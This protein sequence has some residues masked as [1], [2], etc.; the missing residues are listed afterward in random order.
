[1]EL[2]FNSGGGLGVNCSP[3]GNKLCLISPN[4]NHS[5]IV[6]DSDGVEHSIYLACIDDY[7]DVTLLES[8]DTTQ[9]EA[10]KS[11][12]EHDLVIDIP[13]HKKLYLIASFTTTVY[14]GKINIYTEDVDWQSRIQYY[15]IQDLGSSG[16]ED[17]SII[18]YD[19]TD[20]AYPATLINPAGLIRLCNMKIV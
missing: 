20:C 10:I 5:I 16:L 3:E 4:P 17:V 11:L 12:H 2:R 18:V 14:Y 6:K 7:D 15:N 13:A 9:I 8:L 19:N 1:M